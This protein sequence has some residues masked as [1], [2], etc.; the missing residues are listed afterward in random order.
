MRQQRRKVLAKGVATTVLLSCVQI[1]SPDGGCKPVISGNLFQQN[2]AK[3]TV[4]HWLLQ[5]ADGVWAAQRVHYYYALCCCSWPNGV[6]TVAT[7]GGALSLLQ[8]GAIFWSYCNGATPTMTKNR[9]ISNTAS[10]FKGQVG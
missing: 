10:M 4:R 9:F 7:Y 3:I 2:R 6:L 1:G 8:G 5:S